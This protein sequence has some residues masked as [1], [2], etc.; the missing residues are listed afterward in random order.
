[1]SGFPIHKAGP[2]SGV[3]GNLDAS[4]NFPHVLRRGKNLDIHAVWT[5]TPTGTFSLETSYDGGTTFKTVPGA[6]V[7]FTANGN[8]QP[9]GAGGSALWNWSNMPGVVFRLV[10]TSL[11]GSGTLTYSLAMS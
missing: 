11:G 7:E 10:W 9:A 3:S 8:A 6:D 5:G 1:M 4:I 2:G